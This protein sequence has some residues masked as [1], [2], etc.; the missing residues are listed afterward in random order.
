MYSQPFAVRSFSQ[1]FPTDW[2]ATSEPCTNDIRCD[3][4]RAG[5]ASD[6]TQADDCMVNISVCVPRGSV[7]DIRG[8]FTSAGVIGTALKDGLDRWPAD[9]VFPQTQRKGRKKPSAAATSASAGAGDASADAGGVGA[10]VGAGGDGGADGTPVVDAVQ[11]PPDVQDIVDAMPKL[12]ALKA[13]VLSKFAT[14]RCVGPAVLV[15][16]RRGR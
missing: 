11:L 12:E 14:A 15:G 1:W 16:R 7:D 6:V 3:L 5:H 4:K 9:H 13:E 10:G 2:L 8:D